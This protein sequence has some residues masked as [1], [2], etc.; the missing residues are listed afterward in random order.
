MT[1]R[2]VR[3]ALGLAVAASGLAVA[4]ALP[5]HAADGD[6][7]PTYGDPT[8]QPGTV[9]TTFTSS[10]TPQALAMQLDSKIV[11]AGG[12]G[13][14]FGT[15]RY[16]ND[17]DLDG[18]WGAGNGRVVT[19][20]G[21][22]GSPS[23]A[24]AVAVQ[25]IDDKVVVAGFAGNPSNGSNRDFAV[26]R[27]NPDGSLDTSFDTDGTTTVDFRPED[28]ATD[29]ALQADGKIV[30]AGI[31]SDPNAPSSGF[32]V[33]AVIRLKTDGTLDP[34]FDL[35][36]KVT[37]GTGGNGVSA[38][39]VV[40]QAEDDR[41]GRHLE[42]RHDRAGA[43]ELGRHA[44]QFL[45]RRRDRPH[46]RL[47]R[48]RGARRAGPGIRGWRCRTTG[49]S[50]SRAGSRS[51]AA[52]R[53]PWRPATTPTAPS[54]AR[55][56][57][58]ASRSPTS[59]WPTRAPT[60]WPC[61]TTARS[62]SLAT[63]ATTCPWCGSTLSGCSTRLSAATAGSPSRSASATTLAT[64][65][66]C[67][68]TGRCS[69]RPAARCRPLGAGMPRSTPCVSWVRRRACGRRCRPTSWPPRATRGRWC[70]GNRPPLRARRSSPTPSRSSRAVRSR[71]C[72]ATQRCASF[73]GLTNG[74]AYTFTVLARTQLAAGLPGTS[75]VTPNANAAPL[76]SASFVPLPP[77]RILD[78][79]DGTGAAAGKVAKGGS[80]DVMIRGRGGVPDATDVTAVV[81]NV[82]ATEA[83]GPGFVTVYPTGAS[84][85]PN[86]SNLNVSRT[87]QTI[88][89][90]VTVKLGTAGQ[91][92][93]FAFETTHLIG[94]VVG[95]YVA[96]TG[97]TAGRFTPL[98]PARILDTRDGNGVATP[99]KVGPNGEIEL[100]VTGRGGVPGGGVSAVI[101]NVTATEASAPGF[102]TVYPT[103]QTRP[104]GSNLNAETTN[105]TRPNL[106]AVPVG[107]GGRVTLYS[108]S[109]THLVADVAGWFT[110]EGALVSVS[111][112]FVP[113]EPARILDTRDGT[114]VAGRA[115][116]E[117]NSSIDIQVAGLGGLS[118]SRAAAVV[119]NLTATEA[120]DPGYVTAYPAGI[121][122][123]DA[124]NVNVETRNQTIPNAVTV[125]LS[126]TGRLALYSQSGT[127]LA[128]DTFGWYVK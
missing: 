12:V 116:V 119:A 67:R 41:G 86:V 100:Q 50:W 98:T 59:P 64:T 58:A 21:A 101:L 61:R 92:T 78:T 62:C 82:T 53:A 126:G 57:W 128:F 46:R 8:Q 68:S 123:P 125:A 73:T 84:A 65:S 117:P 32:N 31:A 49:A 83:G 72:R 9:S 27:Y 24:F 15:A 56:V 1:R 87:D 127:H 13:T 25:P 35:D 33:M 107:A 48:H 74:V 108:Q 22:T 29:I 2:P 42:W 36:G 38:E 34:T 109:G 110:S 75:T 85:R 71:T 122:R 20:V 63:P 80:I 40:V 90:L 114:G 66:W 43:P 60:P 69:W 23:G 115:K 52:K 30:V 105:Q 76:G 14:G 47:Q 120:T 70:A 93:M 104:Y 19:A 102:I 39:G 81:L 88:P 45:R 96:S 89:N 94:D 95:Y 55:S 3:A 97:S 44:R 118:S 99:G 112:L 54:T 7:D 121:A 16:Y 5:A 106:V 79:R 4:V 10:A 124:S 26:V 103:G 37:V 11:V 51:R 17:G 91:V 113:T 111:G 77:T 18:N 6:I 28:V